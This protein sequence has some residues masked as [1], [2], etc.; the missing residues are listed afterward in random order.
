M[1]LT[2]TQYD[3]IMRSYQDKQLMRHHIITA[4]EEEIAK[5]SPEMAELNARIAHLSVEEAKRRLGVDSSAETD[6]SAR[7][8]A[9]AEAGTNRPAAGSN[10]SETATRISETAAAEQSSTPQE[11]IAALADEKRALL[12]SLGYPEDYLDPPYDC[13]DCQD[14]GYIGSER[15]HCFKQAAI[16]L[17]Y[18]QSHF[19]PILEE[20]CFDHFSLEYYPKDLIDKG[21]GISSYAAAKNTFD[22]C[23]RFVR[24]FDNE[25]Q[26]IYLF[27]DTGLGKTFLTNC[28]AG[29]LIRSGHSVIYFS[30]DRLFQL[31]ADHAFG[32]NT[33]AEADYRSIF[34]CDLLIIDDLGT[35]MTNSFTLS[36]FFVCLNERLLHKRSTLISSNL[37]LQEI[38]SI[39]SER[40]FS[41]ISSS[42]LVLHLFGKDIRVQAN[43]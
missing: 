38:S 22:Q 20:E 40:I 18:E 11:K 24:E 10:M 19:A 28:I 3:E 25:F 7:A 17:V 27:G 29:E 33:A 16:D 43:L 30:A 41:R 13:P 37:G 8:G 23:R 4:R 26:N 35:E 42:F 15:C 39:Y 36:Q 14:T 6:L 12:S 9:P 5:R 21:T 31:L 2:N 34:D 1:P 32:R